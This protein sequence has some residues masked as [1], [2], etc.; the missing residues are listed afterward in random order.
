MTNGFTEE[1]P[2]PEELLSEIA[3]LKEQVTQLEAQKNL[4][5]ERDPVYFNDRLLDEV[6]RSTRY[7]YEFA[8]FMVEM[9]NLES[10]SK[11]TGR[12]ATDEVLSMLGTVFK[13]CLRNT[14]IICHF[15]A[16]KAGMILP[17]TDDKNAHKTAEKLRQT[18]ERVFSLK[19]MSSK[20][21]LTLSIGVA[22][23]PKDA[24]SSEHL[25]RVVTEAL[26]RAV[27]K[28]GNCTCMAVATDASSRSDK[29]T[30]DRSL[31]NETFMQALNDEIQRATRYSQKFSLMILSLGHPGSKGSG[32]D[33]ETRGIVM[34]AVF[35]LTNVTIRTVD[36]GYLYTDTK[37]AIILPNTDAEGAQALA[38]KL[39]DKLT[40]NPVARHNGIEINIGANIGIAAFPLD[41][42]SADGLIWRAEAALSQS[43]KKGYNHFALASSTFKLSGK[44]QGEISD[45]IAGLKDSGAEIVFSL[46][47]SVDLMEH[48]TRSHSQM[49]AKYAM[50]MGQAL[51]LPSFSTRQLRIMALFHDL[52]KVCIPPTII[53]KPATLTSDE[54]EWIFK[55][56]QF[57]ADIL[58]QFPE[59]ADCSLTILA[60]HERWDGK[61]Y[62]QRLKGEAIPLES[63]II[64]VAEAYDDMVTQRPYKKLKSP[65]EAIEELKR[66][67]GTQFD[68]TVVK[69]FIK[70][71]EKL[72]HE[73]SP[74]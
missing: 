2:T 57:G 23:Y 26:S 49:V 34:S 71:L 73:S 31:R 24:I 40:G 59:F 69:V 39:I 74:A 47:A 46:L 42:A 38:H 13:D 65:A 12:D 7:K 60:H 55:H 22:S 4:G 43:L 11:K 14:D 58:A 36:K 25:K 51:G 67:A 10:Y 27:A 37:F 3:Q 6:A 17:Y 54:W 16:G 53:T 15:E 18:A 35:K 33:G 44:D 56:P 61:G 32:L 66:N 64:A 52:G 70:T 48:Y 72:E 68:P 29:S 62:P 45:W 30:T 20:I 5:R 9:D 41:E 21:T 19:S 50:A 8:L 28:G 1:E 63:Q